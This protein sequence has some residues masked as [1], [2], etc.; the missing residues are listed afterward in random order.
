[1]KHRLCSRDEIPE[2]GSR[3][4]SIKTKRKSYDLF[5]VAKN[6]EFYAYKN[7]CPHTGASLNWQQDLFLDLD[8]AFIQCSVHNALFEIDS[9]YCISG[10]CS[11]SSL[12]EL[13]LTIE[14]DDLFVTLN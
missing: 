9:G 14:N 8:H 4:F 10:P 3:E 13:N 5:V 1:M 12:H 7:S 6:G 11:G 2:P